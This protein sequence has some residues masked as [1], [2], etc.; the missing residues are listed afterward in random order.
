MISINGFH[1][2][3]MGKFVIALKK[4]TSKRDSKK[5]KSKHLISKI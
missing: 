2:L 3:N 5:P 1:N 4:A